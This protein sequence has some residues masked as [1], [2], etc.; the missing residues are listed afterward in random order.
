[1]LSNKEIQS[2]SED[3]I[4][5]YVAIEDDLLVN[6]AKRFELADEVTPE[7]VGAWQVKKL[8][9][10]GALRKENLKAL[11]KRSKLTLKQIT[12]IIT[13]A[14][15]K[16]LQFDEQIYNAAYSAGLLVSM[17][18]PMKTS[19]ALNQ[20]LK[21]AIDN[22]RKYFN[23]I[24]T[25]A[26]ESAQ[27]GFLEIINQVYLETSLGITDYNAAIKKGVRNLSDKGITGATYKSAAGRKTRNH[28]D[29]AIRRCIVTSTS[30]AAGQMQIQRAKEWGSN[31]VEA[32]SHMGSRPD[33]AKWQGKIYSLVGETK[34]YPNL[35]KVTGYGTVT[36][37][38]GANCDHDFY[39]FFE[40]ISEQTYKPYNLRENEK[41]YKQ[42]QQQG[43]LERDVRKQKRRILT[44]EQ[45]GD[46]D[47]KL[48]A[49][50]KLKEK[51]AQLKAFTKKT[52]R[53]QRTNRQQVQDFGHSEAGKAV[54]AGRK[55]D[56]LKNDAIIKAQSNL[57]K[58]VYLPDEKLKHTIDVS[59]EKGKALL[60]NGLSG[61]VPMN[62]T[63]SDV[64]VMAGK[65]TSVPI[66]DLKRLYSTYGYSPQNWQKKS[67]KSKGANYEYVVHWYENNGFVPV[68]EMKLKGVGTAK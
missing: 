1:M 41:V 31:L 40:G 46:T 13:D 67:G 4:R 35:V 47:N 34:E 56:F 45:I 7:T 55:V 65:N 20:I 54:W 22:T 2:L 36:G 17:P 44:A 63:L 66:R 52:G 42:S 16:A 28:I 30:Q 38:K 18:V 3:I 33:H 50:L 14:G 58:R 64:Y 39:P 32:T 29:T 60:S 27:D 62:S 37:L 43:K 9:Q 49:Q 24:N 61:V 5:L 59:I 6:V 48:K 68:D 15:F 8:E 10:L 19:P 53:T 57:P 23:L 11:S 25:T 51:E 21:G 12:R 26:L